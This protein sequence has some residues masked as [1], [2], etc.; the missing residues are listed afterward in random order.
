MKAM[1]AVTCWKV[2]LPLE[3]LDAIGWYCLP[4]DLH[5]HALQPFCW[6][7]KCIDMRSLLALQKN[8]LPFFL[9]RLQPAVWTLQVNAG[10]TWLI[11]KALSPPVIAIQLMRDVQG[12]DRL[13]SSRLF[14]Q[15]ISFHSRSWLHQHI[16]LTSAP[17]N[18]R[19]QEINSCVSQLR[20]L[21]STSSQPLRARSSGA[22][23]GNAAGVRN[24]EVKGR[25]TKPINPRSLKVHQNVPR[26]GSRVELGSSGE[27]FEAALHGALRC[28][29]LLVITIFGS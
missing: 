29:R 16:S 15:Q 3:Q 17:S 27:R 4:E 5:E 6:Q 9:W 18:Y 8:S 19:G 23:R 21:G 14:L 10:S 25:G 1:K 24:C 26:S 13:C 12:L 20:S 28:F 22:W 7:I 2:F 11:P